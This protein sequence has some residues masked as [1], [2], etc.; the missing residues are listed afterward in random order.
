MILLN[1]CNFVM[2]SSADCFVGERNCFDLT[3]RSGS[4]RSIDTGDTGH[5]QCF[6][7]LMKFVIFSSDNKYNAWRAFMLTVVLLR[8]LLILCTHKLLCEFNKFFHEGGWLVSNRV[9][10]FNNCVR[11]LRVLHQL[12]WQLYWSTVVVGKDF[13]ASFGINAPQRESVCV[14]ES[15]GCGEGEWDSSFQLPLISTGNMHYNPVSL[16][17]TGWMAPLNETGSGPLC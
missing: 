6:K 8:Q 13:G 10:S 15:G 16:P 2:N 1:I 3:N 17:V 11:A 9:P 12:L 4:Q 14:S 5:R 7:V